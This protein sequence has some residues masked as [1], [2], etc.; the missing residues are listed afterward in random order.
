[1]E[2]GKKVDGSF[3][4]YAPNKGAPVFFAV[5]FLATGGVHLWQAIH[6]KS[7][8]L[9]GL[10]VLCALL[11]GSG[12]IVRELGAFEYTNLGYYIASQCLIYFAP[13]LYELCN[14]YILG[15]IL[16]FVPYYSPIHPGRVLTTFAAISMAVE[17]LNGNGIAYMANRSLPEEQQRAGEALMKAS[18]IL[19]LFVVSL[20]VVLAGV[21][22]TRCRRN[23]IN[24]VKVNEAL[25]TLYISTAI[26]MVRCI[27][28]TVEY[29]GST[30]VD[31]SDP[32]FDY[33]ALSPIVRYEWFFY[34]FE[35]TLM[36]CNS[37]LLNVRHPRRWLPSS[38]KVYLAKDNVTEIMGPGYKQERNFLVTLLDPFDIYGMIKGKDQATRFWDDNELEGRKTDVDPMLSTAE[39]QTN[40]A[41]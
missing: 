32:N 14:Y 27:Y 13:P 22:Q 17:A 5:A 41:V 40:R 37:V 35:A 1:M 38:T 15:R 28:R 34:V 18:L 20:F 2:D 36:L 33:S 9:T 10:Y 29:F 39:R 31:F 23:G 19:Q 6:Y 3:Y 11:F 7:W 8:K 21:F 30:N 12:F 4:I 16:Y 25:L 26:I 24:H